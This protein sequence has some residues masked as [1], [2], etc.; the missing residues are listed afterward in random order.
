MSSPITAPPL[1]TVVLT[2]F[3]GAGKTTLLNHLLANGR[4][5]RI[6]ALVNEFGTVDIDSSLL[7]TERAIGTGV[8]ELANGCICCT[9]ND[10]LRDAVAQILERRTELDHL[11]IE[12]TG[13]ADPGPVLTTLR[14]PEFARG[15]RVDAVVTVVD[16][17]SVLRSMGADAPAPTKAPAAVPKPVTAPTDGKA[18]ADPLLGE[19]ECHR[20]QLSLA[21]ML[22]INK[23]DLLAA[24]SLR[25]VRTRLSEAAPRARQLTCAHGRLAPEL[26]LSAPLELSSLA[27]AD[28]GA[29]AAAASGGAGGPGAPAAAAVQTASAEVA[30]EGGS[31]ARAPPWA[32]G[33]SLGSGGATVGDSKRAREGHLVRDGFRSIAFRP[34][35]PLHLQ[36]FECLRRSPAWQAVVRAKGFLRFAE[37]GGFRLTVQQAGGRFDVVASECASPSEEGSDAVLVLIGQSLD[38]R[39][40]LDGLRACEV[41]V[42]PCGDPSTVDEKGMAA[43]C[44]QCEGDNDPVVDAHAPRQAGTVAAQPTV[45]TVEAMPAAVAPG[46]APAAAPATSE[47]TAKIAESLLSQMRRDTRFDDAAAQVLAGGTLISLRLIGWLGVSAEDLTWQLLEQVNT[48]AASG[49]AWLAP[50]RI[51]DTADTPSGAPPPPKAPLMLLQPLH[52]DDS[53]PVVWS[54]LYDATEAVMRVHFAAIYCGGCDCLENLAGQVL[55]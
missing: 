3:L 4:G 46:G 37:S 18:G 53:A 12:T 55:T 8:V 13:I 48:G 25:S 23:T 34:S 30:A 32:A 35:R 22:V 21:D 44:L 2:G 54:R 40:L 39:A 31:S 52:A 16:A 14:L 9:I 49:D 7:V 5:L 51:G 45:V 1:P 17:A 10:S 47:T 19:L 41:D 43:A 6:G 33:R 50:C 27:I 38:E 28:T 15:L 11:V 24:A 29:I 36:R 42:P 20:R 26:L